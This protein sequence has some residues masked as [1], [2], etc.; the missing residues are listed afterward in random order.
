[1]VLVFAYTI[2]CQLTVVGTLLREAA[3][4][5]KFST[6]VDAWLQRFNN[7]KIWAEFFES[8]YRIVISLVAIVVAIVGAWKGFGG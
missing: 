5:H 2:T 4:R 6:A 7:G 3:M 1:M 8:M